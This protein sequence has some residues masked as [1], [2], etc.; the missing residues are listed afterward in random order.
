VARIWFWTAADDGASWYRADQPAGALRWAGHETWVSEVPIPSVA[1]KADVIV[2]SRPAR[3]EALKRLSELRA[4]YGCRIVAD[5]DDDYW[6]MEPGTYAHKS[7]HEDED[8]A[9]IKGLEEGLALAD[10]VTVASSGE[11]AACAEHG[12]QPDKISVVPNGLHASILGL[13]RDYE[14]GTTNDG[15]LTI[16]WSGT[17]SSIEGL[18]LVGRALSR[19]LTRYAGK[20]RV[21]LVGFNPQVAPEGFRR[22][23]T[24]LADSPAGQADVA[25]TEWVPHGDRYLSA[26]GMFDIWLAP[27]HNTAFNLAKFPTK[28]LEAGF[29]GIPLIA[30]DI[31][32]YQ[33]WF[34]GTHQGDHARLVSEYVPHEWSRQLGRL[35]ESPEL[36]RRYGE[37]ARSA[38][39][40]YSLQEVGRR[41]ESVLLG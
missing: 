27:Y 22:A 23:M 6:A 39:A 2:V 11:A 21:R 18:D 35:I 9:L 37:A 1:A 31:T 16:G 17:A 32:P 26:V 24:H 41:W 38:A 8:G 29:W 3:P 7:W 36:R 30:S 15:V 34:A 5:L 14:C 25:H 10:H 40:A 12:V 4:R 13:P 33:E 20:V 28:A 19:A